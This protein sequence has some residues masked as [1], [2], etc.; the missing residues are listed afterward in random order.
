MREHEKQKNDFQMC[1]KVTT[2]VLLDIDFARFK[3]IKKSTL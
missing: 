2:Y 3:L 1:V